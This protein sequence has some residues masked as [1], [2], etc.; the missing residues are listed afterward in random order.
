VISALADPGSFRDPSG[1]VFQVAGKIY[2]VLTAEAAES[3]CAARDC[4]LIDSLVTRGM[5]LPAIGSDGA[6]LGEHAARAAMVLEHPRVPFISY[7]YEW[8]FAAHRRAALLHL[9]LHTAALER[10][11]TLSDA[12]AYNVQ[13]IGARPVFIDHLSLRPYRDGEI[14]AGHRQFCMQFLNPLLLRARRG[15]APNAW[16]RGA[17]EGVEP[18]A[19][20][21]L[22]SWRDR[23]SWTVL[24]HVVL[25]VALQ[26]RAARPDAVA[27]RRLKA[28]RLPR[29]SFK[30]MLAGLRSA[31]AAM[32]PAGAPTTWGKYAISHSYSDADMTLKRAFV[33]DMV[34][35]VRPRQLWDLGCNT[36]DFAALALES[37]AEYVVGF[38]FDHDAL[39][40][41]FARAE[42]DGLAFQPLWLDAANPSPDQGWAQQE[43]GGLQTRAG[44]DAL[45][46]LA[47]V[48]HIAIG[49]NVPL[50]R[51]VGWLIGIAPTGIIEFP[52]RGD[53]MVE[54]LLALRQDVFRDFTTDAFFAAVNACA[55]IVRSETTS[56]GRH[57]V[58]YDR[59]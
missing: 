55:R 38:D 52:P 23:L 13:F 41:A 53:P 39:D 24:S 5:L 54:Q 26:R 7:P 35:K 9:D 47:L 46:A 45:L 34:D 44:A 40:G 50:D 27:T 22:L 29:A 32:R 48:H 31:I 11:F 17:L 58:W 18:E 49:R 57:L 1:R 4:G 30:A 21:P 51:A 6:A 10:G 25:Q 16:F 14:W 12:T 8:S 42:R 3:F 33:A 37:G 20:A 19:L 15:V 56:A 36:G 59:G 43:R 2:R 28:A